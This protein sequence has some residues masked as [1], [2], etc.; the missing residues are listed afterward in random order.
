MPA[1]H[2]S[3]RLGA[4]IIIGGALLTEGQGNDGYD[5]DAGAFGKQPILLELPGNCW[6]L[7]RPGASKEG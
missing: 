4:A 5:S 3:C 6:A 2:V 7:R 1:M